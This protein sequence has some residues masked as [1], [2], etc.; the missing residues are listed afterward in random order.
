MFKDLEE[1]IDIAF[2]R[3]PKQPENP[4]YLARV[5]KYRK[6]TSVVLQDLE[7]FPAFESRLKAARALS[8]LYDLS[9]RERDKLIHTPDFLVVH[10]PKTTDHLFV[11]KC[12]CNDWRSHPND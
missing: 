1:R 6:G 8:T 5:L 11:V 12:T 3:T 9:I 7:S 2:G 10:K 4:H